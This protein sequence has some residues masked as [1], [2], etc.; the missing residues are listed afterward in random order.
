MDELIAHIFRLAEFKSEL[1]PGG[2]V[3]RQLIGRLGGLQGGRVLKIPGVRRLLKTH[4]PMAT[5]TKRSALQ[6]IGNKEPEIPW[7]TLAITRISLSG[8]ARWKQVWRPEMCSRT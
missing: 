8:L 3:L 1:S 4:G 5:F 7:P 6:L 2:V